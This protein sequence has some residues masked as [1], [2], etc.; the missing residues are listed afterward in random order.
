MA[1]LG[2]RCERPG[3]C[4]C[5]GPGRP[6]ALGGSGPWPG[7]LSAEQARPGERGRARGRLKFQPFV[8]TWPLGGP[9]RFSVRAR[10]PPAERWGPLPE[11]CGESARGRGQAEVVSARLRSGCLGSAPRFHRPLWLLQLA[12]VGS[13]F[14]LRSAWEG[15]LDAD[16]GPRAQVARQPGP[17]RTLRSPGMWRGPPCPHAEMTKHLRAGGNLVSFRY[18]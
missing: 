10:R 2:V 17:S 5:P 13:G 15:C 18:S 16:T 4:G 6:A 12:G 9:R 8:G 7:R 3:G 14:G 1:G 11:L